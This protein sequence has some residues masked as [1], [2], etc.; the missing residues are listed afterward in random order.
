[1]NTDKKSKEYVA[2][3]AKTLA[4][5][6]VCPLGVSI[7]RGYHLAGQKAVRSVVDELIA[8]LFP[9]CHGKETVKACEMEK[10]MAAQ[11]LS[12]KNKLQEQIA[13]ALQYQCSVDGCDDC[14]DC[15]IRAED[16][17]RYLF[18]SLPEIKKILEGDILAAYEGDPAARS[19][20][21]VVMSYP[22]VFAIIVHRIAHFLY[23]ENIPMIPRIMS[24]YAHSLTG[25]DIHPGATIGK[26][27]FIDHGT[28]VVIGETC[29]IG[30]RVKLYQGVTLGARSFEKDENGNPVKG[31]KRH[32]NVGNNVVIYAGATILGGETTIGDDSEI[33]GNVWL[34]HSVPPGSKVY[35]RQPRPLIKQDGH[36]S[37]K[38]GPDVDYG[39]GI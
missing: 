13:L 39:A 31:I 5:C 33:G 12:V 35:N 14:E 22:G 23:K 34:I 18:D 27:F 26:E 11:L 17:V 1:M 29:T 4:K 30:E 38:N 32:P 28:G 19:T 16:V 25:I 9:G 8:A 3:K 15:N 37:V 20:M 10:Y 2:G 7:H 6:Q 21:E 36:W 24:E